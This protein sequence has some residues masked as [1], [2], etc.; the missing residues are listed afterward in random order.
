VVEHE[1]GHQYWYGMVATNEFEDAWMDEG[2]NSYTEVKVL[3]AI[4][5]RDTSILNIAGAT[6]GERELQRATY[7]GP[8]DLDPIAQKAYDYYNFNSY[9]G[10]TYGKTA[11]VLVTLEGIVGEDTMQKAM[12]AYFMKYRFTHPVKEDFLKTIEEVSGKDLRWYF[13][14]A[15]YGTQVLD[16]EVIKID[17]FPVN[18]YEDQKKASKKDDKNTVYLSTIWVHRKEDFTMPVEVEIKFDNG[19]RVREHWDGQNRWTKFS[20]EKKSKAESAEIDPDHK[21]YI[22]RNNFN[23]SR[24]AEPKGKPALKMSN[25]WLFVTQ[26]MSQALAWW[27]V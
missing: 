21:I 16:Y 2:I 26:W 9:G 27:A 18:W 14:Q 25:Y 22:D 12:H 8:A 3:D 5:G 19:E 17:S 13:N 24:T 4:L 10:I 1:F 20:Y 6:A 11:S 15:I 23:N 7:I